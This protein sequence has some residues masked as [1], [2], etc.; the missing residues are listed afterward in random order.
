MVAEACQSFLSS[1]NAVAEIKALKSG[2]KGLWNA[3][4]KLFTSLFAKKQDLRRNER[5]S[6][7]VADLVPAHKRCLGYM[8]STADEIYVVCIAVQIDGTYFC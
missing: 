6:R 4:K 8:V 3:L 2:N 1:K 7:S 5:F